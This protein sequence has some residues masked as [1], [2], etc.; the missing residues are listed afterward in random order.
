MKK[1]YLFLVALIAQFLFL[2]SVKAESSIDTYQVTAEK[3]D[4]SRN[5]L[6]TTTGTSAYSFDQEAIGNSALGNVTSLN[7]LL[8]QAPGVTQDSVG[9]IH[10][11]NDHSNLQYRINGIILPESISSFGQ[12]LD[13]HFIDNVTLLTGALPAQYGYRTA[14]VVDIKI[15]QGT[16]KNGGRS[17]VTVG[18][19]ETVGGN[20]EF[21]GSS[22]K[23]NYY[24]NT[25]YLQNNRGIE[26]PTSSRNPIHDFTKQDKQFGYFSYLLN[27]TSRLSVILGNATN[28]FEIPNN[29]GQQ[30]SFDVNGVSKNDFSSSNLDENQRESSQYAIAAL[31]GVLEN[32]IDYQLSLFSRRSN[33]KFKPDYMGDL[34][35][36]GVASDID[37]TSQVNGSQADFSYKINEQNILR[38]GFFI[39]RETTKSARDTAVF[40]VDINGD[41]TSSTPFSIGDI[42][43]QSTNLYGLYLQNEWKAIDNL[44]INY[45][46]RFDSVKSQIDDSQ[47]SPRFGAIYD[48]SKNTKLHAGYSKYFTPPSSDLLSNSKLSQFVGTSNEPENL[49]NDKV[50]AERT[51]YYDLGIHHKLT[52]N[53]NIGLDG[54]YKDIENLLD[55]GQF[56]SALIYTPFN[57]EKAKTYGLEFSS[58]YQRDNLSAYFNLSWTK[59]RAKNVISGQYLLENDELQYIA[60]NYVNPDHSQAYTASAGIAYK[61]Y[62]TN[63]S[64]DAIYGS[65]LRKGFAN[66]RKMP[67]YSQVNAAVNRDFTL[68]VINKF[69]A[70]ISV[71]NLFDEVYQLHDGSGIGIGAPQYGPR[72]GYYLTV[73]KSF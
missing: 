66:T 55:K 45:G 56:G 72:R 65:G 3:L 73:A 58:D 23:L 25:S 51:D 18:S 20:Q 59:S 10:V 1:S 63:Y 16:F 52:K 26:A 8:L 70:R 31:Q 48:F 38:S 30:A 33:L 41:Q 35:F 47:L 62:Q 71:I 40:S 34:A 28:R 15:K 50:R 22:G 44:T 24:L 37:Q 68:P 5:N 60:D 19:N 7:K 11:R 49:T 27:D 6:S 64:L 12:I 69:N 61:L 46:A 21:S 39:S 2:A 43:N 36:N 57:Y 9:Q 32:G 4:K 14:G 54:Y 13:V 67:S 17:E 53:L 42:N 29:P